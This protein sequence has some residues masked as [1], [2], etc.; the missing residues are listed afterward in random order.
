MTPPDNKLPLSKE[1][2]MIPLFPLR[3]KIALI[4]SLLAS[5]YAVQATPADASAAATAETSASSALPAAAGHIRV[6]YHR[7]KGDTANWGVYSWLG[8]K[9]PSK[10]WI[11]DRFMFEGKDGFGAY[12]DIALD[13]AKTEMRFLVSNERGAKNCGND[14]TVKLNPGIASSAQEIWVLESD[15]AIHDKTPAI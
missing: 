12:V 2:P 15:C 1:T 9:N 14:Q 7:A 6:H 11:A 10:T 4:L 5:P 8:P 3:A 13:T